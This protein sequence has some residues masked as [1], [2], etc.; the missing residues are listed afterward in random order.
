MTLLSEMQADSPA[1]LW[2]LDETAGATTAE[3]A[4]ANN[5]DGT[6][7]APTFGATGL[8]PGFT[9]ASF[10]GTDDRIHSATYD[11]FVASSARTFCG[12]AYRDDATGIDAFF[13]EST[14]GTGG[15]M[16][17]RVGATD[18][19]WEPSL[20]SA[21]GNWVGV[22]PT[23]TAFMW[24]LTFDEP[25]DTA[26]LFI[27]G[28][29]QGAKT[30]ATNYPGAADAF[31]LGGTSGNHWVGRHAFVGVYESVLSS[32]RILAH[33]QAAFA[34]E[35]PSLFVVQSGLRFA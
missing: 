25:S 9:C 23:A 13:M 28:V 12:V 26:E 11:P 20:G 8:V 30:V 6:A 2:K 3:D 32:A 19:T 16:A 14:G 33:A 34:T 5:R 18:I 10:D 17:G 15:L 24:H 1:F 22:C 4:T 29:S 27:D 7:S 35:P 31:V 21:T